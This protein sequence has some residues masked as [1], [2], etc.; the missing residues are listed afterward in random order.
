MPTNGNHSTG[1]VLLFASGA[2]LTPTPPPSPALAAR[3]TT[4][5]AWRGAVHPL[6]REK[7]DLKVGKNSLSR[8]YRTYTQIIKI[9]V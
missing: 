2:S 5:A 9:K 7:R 3:S 6:V 8:L 1:L 4:L